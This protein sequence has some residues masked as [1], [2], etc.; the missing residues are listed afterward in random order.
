MVIE[1]YNSRD[2]RILQSRRRKPMKESVNSSLTLC[3]ICY[4]FKHRD[5]TPSNSSPS[6]S[7]LIHFPEIL[8]DT[9]SE[10]EEGKGI[11][12]L[13]IESG[14]D[15]ESLGEW[16]EI[17]GGSWR[18][19]CSPLI[20]IHLQNHE[21]WRPKENRS[22]SPRL[23][24]WPPKIGSLDLDRFSWEGLDMGSLGH[25]SWLSV[26]GYIPEILLP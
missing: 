7:L 24:R 26:E 3:L 13:V 12:Q 18:I 16:M 4:N 6:S 11:Q 10:W 14:N 23:K 1:D 17:R 15:E 9:G 2:N 19:E 5:E 25:E 22:P 8:L 20:P 21:S